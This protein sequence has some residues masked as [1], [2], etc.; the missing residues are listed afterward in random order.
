M[1]EPL[2]LPFLET[3]KEDFNLLDQYDAFINTKL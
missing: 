1:Y 3:R 2:F